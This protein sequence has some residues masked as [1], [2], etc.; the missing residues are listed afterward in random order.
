MTLP[1]KIAD[2]SD[3]FMSY[4]KDYYNVPD[5]IGRKVEY[6][7]K[8]GIIYMDG[9]NYVAVNFDNDKPGECSYIHPADPDLKYGEM[10]QVRK[11]TPSQK[12]YQDYVRSDSTLTFAEYLGIR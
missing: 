1:E 9:G 7:G 2:K 5:D 12:R 3:N 4:V 11:L 10:G 6:K 8:T